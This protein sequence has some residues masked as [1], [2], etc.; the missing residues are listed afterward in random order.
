MADERRDDGG[1]GDAV[2]DDDD[3][4]LRW[5]GADDRWEEAV[6]DRGSE[7]PRQKVRVDPPVSDV[8]WDE[9]AEDA[10]P[11]FVINQRA[12]RSGDDE[13]SPHGDPLEQTAEA[14]A[15]SVPDRPAEAGARMGNL[16]DALASIRERVQSLSS[17]IPGP[18]RQGA[19]SASQLALYRAATDDRTLSELRRHGNETENLLRRLAAN[20]QDLSTDLRSIVDAARRAIDQ[21]SEQ[22]ESSIELGRLLGERIEQMDADTTRRLDDINGEFSKRFTKLEQRA[23]VGVLREEVSELRNDVGDLRADLAAITGGD[24]SQ[25]QAR[26]DAVSAQLDNTIAVLQEAIEG[27]SGDDDLV[28]G[29]VASIRSETEAAVEPF[30]NEV[31]E[32]GRQLSEALDREEQ[33]GS[34][35]G[36]LTA[37][38]ARLRKRIAVRATPPTIDDD[39]VQNI[40]DAVVAA[41]QG[42]R[43]AATRTPARRR[44]APEPEPDFEDDVEAEEEPEEEPELAPAKR[45]LRARPVRAPRK[46]KRAAEPEPE[47][48]EP[49]YEVD[50][51]QPFEPGELEL[52]DA[53]LDVEPDEEP[54]RRARGTRTTKRADRPLRGRRAR[55]QQ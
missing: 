2:A 43:P 28:E 44:R 26:M 49:E 7:P 4:Q 52:A 32:L 42:R 55:S 50:I 29:V 53:V 18:G 15:F 25:L 34:T 24:G 23:G 30:R 14:E 46:A 22:A 37:E 45:P 8:P 27:P 48:E 54:I 3:F 35:L 31:E 47:E 9:L 41:T 40:V 19:A 36:E 16:Q 5:G 21:T 39:Q 6:A 1:S 13:T 12:E 11:E 17:D 51:N 38:V 20:L 33:L 10:A